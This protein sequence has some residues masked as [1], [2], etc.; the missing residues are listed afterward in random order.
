MN[1]PM[2]AHDERRYQRRADRLRCAR[3]DARQQRAIDERAQDIA[4]MVR[5]A[6][7]NN[8]ACRR[9]A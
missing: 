1:E 4:L 2:P 5:V 9:F 8:L 6:A 3:I 7:Q